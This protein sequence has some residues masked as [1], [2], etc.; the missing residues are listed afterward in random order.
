MSKPEE[1]VGSQQTDKPVD[2]TEIEPT[3]ED[4]AL[5]LCNLQQ[6]SQLRQEINNIIDN[7]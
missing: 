7:L 4:H 5:I 1:L 2:N 6:L 3:C